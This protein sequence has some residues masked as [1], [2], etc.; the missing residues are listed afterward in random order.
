MRGIGEVRSDLTM[1]I[2]T[3]QPHFGR[4]PPNENDKSP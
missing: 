3:P 1:I 4:T 2:T